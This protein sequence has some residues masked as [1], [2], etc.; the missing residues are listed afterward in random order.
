MAVIAFKLDLVNQLG[1]TSRVEAFFGENSSET[2]GKGP[3]K[4]VIK[5]LFLSFS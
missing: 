2:L 5:I 1:Q 4:K 3:E